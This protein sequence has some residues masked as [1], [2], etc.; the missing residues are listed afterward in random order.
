MHFQT[1]S[2]FL[3]FAGIGLSSAQSSTATQPSSTGPASTASRT[4][5]GTA[6]VTPTVN[7]FVP[8]GGLGTLANVTSIVSACSDRTVYAL[9]CTSGT[10]AFSTC[11]AASPVCGNTVLPYRINTMALITDEYRQ[12]GT[13]TNSHR[14]AE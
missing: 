13:A 3:L 14:R 5:T 10:M 9:R 6:L 11:D 8:A 4:S 7:L 2:A 12:C 1:T